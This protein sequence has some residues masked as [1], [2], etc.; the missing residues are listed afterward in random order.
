M[1]NPISSAI[2]QVASA[3]ATAVTAP[4]QVAQQVA[5][6]AG[7]PAIQQTLS[8]LQSAT[9][10]EVAKSNPLA[11]PQ[12]F[13]LPPAVY[14]NMSQTL[15]QAHAQIEAAA[16]APPAEQPKNAEG[17]ERKSWG[18]IAKL[19]R[20]LNKA[21]KDGDETKANGILKSMSKS[22]MSMLM[23]MQFLR[24][25][26]MQELQKCMSKRDEF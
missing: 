26:R 1:I 22:D 13:S 21:L 15:S 12:P 10:P 24:D 20:E 7:L 2:Q 9:P 25:Q 19:E 23:V 4:V 6:Q 3:A 14:Q 11:V 17:G 18:D 8:R 16:Q 5:T